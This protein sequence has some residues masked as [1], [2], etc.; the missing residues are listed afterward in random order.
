MSILQI[1][2]FLELARLKIFNV[3]FMLQNWIC[4]FFMFIYWDILKKLQT[5]PIF[6]LGI[7]RLFFEKIKKQ[8]RKK[9]RKIK[10]AGFNKSWNLLLPTG[11]VH[12]EGFE[13]PTFRFVAEHSIQ[14]S[15]WCI[16]NI[17][18]ESIKK[19]NYFFATLL[20]F[21]FFRKQYNKF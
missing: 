16:I 18:Q 11:L 19:V 14:L 3:T 2:H 17:I 4:L 9:S 5:I 8:L 13:P 21:T 15:Y 12:Q 1:I 6:V 10:I 20:K 7:W